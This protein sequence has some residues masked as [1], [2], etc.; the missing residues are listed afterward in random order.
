MLFRVLGPLAVEPE[1]GPLVLAGSRTRALLTALLLDPGKLV[2]VWRGPAY[3]EFADGFACA[4]ASGRPN[5]GGGKCGR[6]HCRTPL[7]RTPGR[8]RHAGAHRRSADARGPCDLPAP[9]RPPARRTRPG[10]VTSTARSSR[11]RPA[12]RAGPDRRGRSPRLPVGEAPARARPGA[13]AG[14]T[15]PARRAPRGTGEPGHH[16]RHSAAGDAG[17]HR[18]GRQDPHRN[19]PTA[20]APG[21]HHRSGVLIPISIHSVYTPC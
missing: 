17:R 12:V 8:P 15:L 11:T 16:A 10:P 20:R 2:P 14:T 1:T 19:A 18:R 21:G 5:R 9:L 7:A 13:A 3:G 4:A 6:H